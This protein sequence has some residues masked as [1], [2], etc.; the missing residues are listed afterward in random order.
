EVGRVAKPHGL[1]GEVV[2]ALSTNRPER[3]AKGTVLQ[4]DDGPLTITASR[5]H[6]HRWIVRFDGVDTREAAEALH[7]VVLRAE[8]LDDPDALWVHE[9][10]GSE[11]VELD[12]TARGRVA[13]VLANPADDLLELEGGALVPLGFMVERDAEGRIVVDVPDGLFDLGD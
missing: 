10:V 11:V 6:Q 7:G 3:V 9:L 4:T 8:P 1:R 2:V 5:P 13:A 12:G